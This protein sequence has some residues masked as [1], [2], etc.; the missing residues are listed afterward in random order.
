MAFARTLRQLHAKARCSLGELSRAAGVD[1]KHIRKLEAGSA[2]NPQRSTIISLGQG[3]LD[4]SG[5]I[6]PADVKARLDRG[7]DFVLVD[8]REQHEWDICNIPGAKLIPLSEFEDRMD[9]LDTD[10]DIVLHCK[11]GGRSAKAQ[12]ILF[13]NGY[14]KVKNMVGGVTRWADDVDPSMPKY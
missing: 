9:E 14:S 5:D 8:V 4:L 6:T 7:E 11:M 2:R 12:D 13:A 10:A 3:L 1:E